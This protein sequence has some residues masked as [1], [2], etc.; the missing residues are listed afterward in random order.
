MTEHAFQYVFG[1][2]V[3][4]RLGR[5]LGVDVIPFKTCVYDC[6]Y[7][8]LGKTTCHTVSRIEYTPLD[9][10]L[11]EV[12][13][14]VTADPDVADYITIAGSGEPTLYSRLGELV[15]GIKALT[16]I[17]VAVITNGALLWNPAV[18]EALMEVDLLVP[19]LDAADETSFQTVNRGCADITF[20]QM[21]AGLVSFRK[22]FKGHFW[23]EIFLLE[24]IT[25]I[26]EQV[27]KFAALIDR[28]NPERVQL[29]TVSRPAPDGNVFPVS[30]ERMEQIARRLGH[31]AEVIAHYAG[32]PVVAATSSASAKDLWDLIRRHPCTLEDAAQGLG[33]SLDVAHQY[34]GALL[35]E[36]RLRK[37]VKNGETF[38]LAL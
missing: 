9:A 1:P 32:T 19:S 17:P 6:I 20:D 22:K 35:A 11:N 31:E 30:P 23:L 36:N 15:A 38:Y 10:L 25:G 2:V 24:G 29:N 27:D 8:Q 34:A 33:L 26:P 12:R 3:S 14:K 37:D 21:V 5:S 4:R 7:C 18:Q 13:L 28:I 16:A